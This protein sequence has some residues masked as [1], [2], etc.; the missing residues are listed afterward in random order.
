MSC[1]TAPGLGCC[2]THPWMDTAQGWGEGALGSPRVQEGFFPLFSMLVS[3]FP[4]PP[5]GSM[6][7]TWLELGWWE[8]PHG[9]ALLQSACGQ[10]SRCPK[11]AQR[12]SAQTRQFWGGRKRHHRDLIPGFSFQRGIF[13]FLTSLT[14]SAPIPST[15]QPH[16]QTLEGNPD[17]HLGVLLLCP[18]PTLRMCQGNEV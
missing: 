2:W 18:F 9:A 5:D 13:A 10:D 16:S 4:S 12:S 7:K 1:G 14:R 17:L 8:I 15:I 6:G 11:D 3:R